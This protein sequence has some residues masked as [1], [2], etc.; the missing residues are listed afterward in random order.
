MKKTLLSLFISILFLAG[1][2]S[3]YQYVYADT[4][5]TA[6]DSSNSQ[7]STQQD[8]RMVS[9]FPA[10]GTRGIPVNVPIAIKFSSSI[11]FS[12]HPEGIR[13]MSIPV[14]GTYGM[15]REIGHKIDIKGD[16]L[17]LYPYNDKYDFNQSVEV[18]IP[19]NSLC[20]E[21]GNQQ[22]QQIRITYQACNEFTRLM[23]AD[24]YET[25]L[26]I[27][28]AGW[29][30]ADTVVLSSGEDYPDALSAGPLAKEFQAPIILSNSKVLSSE[31]EQ[32]LNR[33]GTRNVIIVGGYASISKD[34]EDKLKA[35]DLNISRFGGKDRYETCMLIAQKVGISTDANGVVLVSGSGYADALSIASYAAAHGLPIILTEKDKL[36]D[37]FVEFVN[38]N[39]KSNEPRVYIV[40][41]TG[42]ISKSVE[43]SIPFEHQ[44]FA[45]SDRY[46]TNFEVLSNLNHDYSLSYFASG[47]NF[48]DALSGSV[49]AALGKSSIVLVSPNMR[50]DIIS[51]W[52]YN[53]KLFVMKLILGG[54]GAV[55]Q[56]VINS[57]FN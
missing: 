3:P 44:R 18:Y 2:A 41:G 39:S 48:P 45:G 25:S 55:P 14:G 50:E 47:E 51:T 28:Q 35:K 37:D 31:I 29:L 15:G 12:D 49:L 5:G 34:I 38:K 33:L 7:G 26:K 17:Y 30:K 9:V 57:I 23:G 10:D 6:I 46:E 54:E 16:T 22:E 27:S 52:R 11:K 13:I 42:V 20:D 4:T 36:P 32:E 21:N 8:I 40:G 53:K 56:S 43:D 24:R 1:L 19:P